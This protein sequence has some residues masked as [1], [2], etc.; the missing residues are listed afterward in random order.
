MPVYNF[1]SNP[2]YVDEGQSI[3]F[4]YEAPPDFD[5]TTVVTIQVGEYQT[6][7][8]IKTKAE[9]FAPDDF[10]LL[11]FSPAEKDRYYTC[12]LYTSPSPRDS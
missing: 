10:T 6:L 8:V 12:L 11:D 5:A 1:S 7:W 4:R 9:D 2:L 3:Q